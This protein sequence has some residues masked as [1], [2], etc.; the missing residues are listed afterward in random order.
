MSGKALRLVPALVLVLALVLGALPTRAQQPV[1]VVWFIGL[2]TG[3][4]PEQQEMQNKVAEQFNATHSDIQL[5]IVVADYNVARDTLSTLIASG[6]SPDIVGPVGNTGANAFAG[7]WLDLEPLVEKTGYDLSQ[8][9]QAAVDF[10]RTP[11]GL[12]GLPFATFPSFL[13]YRPALFDEAGLP[14]PPAAYGE[15]YA[16]G[17]TWDMDKLREVAMQL[18]VDANGYDATEPEFDPE[19]IVQWGFTIQW[20]DPRGVPTL[21]G[22]GH[23][24]DGQGNAIMPEH[25]RTGWKW[26]YDAIW[27]DHFMPNEAQVGSDLLGAGNPFAS[28]N[29]AMATTHLW[30]TC[31][32]AD[33]EWQAA[34]IP[35][36]NGKVTAKL[37]ADTFRI[38]KTSKNPEAAFEVL[39][40]LIGEASLDLLSV[41]GGM[42]ARETDRAAFFEGLNQKYTQGV[43]WAVVMDSLNYPDIPSHESWM[44]NYNKAEDLL[45]NFVTLYGSTPGLDMDAELDKLVADLQAVFDEVK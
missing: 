8:F 42:P 4:Q 37:H 9:P 12:I 27:K 44:P 24:Y 17:D 38:L 26:I 43:N 1:K 33:T 10:Y 2:G 36:Y 45:R 13:W 20:S 3:G 35:S 5:E 29:V 15:P 23:V 41:Y 34:A 7:N 30:Y 14:Y 18:T 31:C 22:A 19:N 16:D 25:W 40:Y 11:E 6:D 39:T 32:I 28:G 21:F